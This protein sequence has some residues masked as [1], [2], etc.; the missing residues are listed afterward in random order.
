MGGQCER[1]S[2]EDVAAGAMEHAHFD[3]VIAAFAL[4]LIPSSYLKVVMTALARSCDY[5]V[6][7]S[8]HK[9]PKIDH[10]FAW[11]LVGPE[12]LHHR[13]HVRC[14]TSLG[15][16]E[17]PLETPDVATVAAAR[18][19]AAAA[20]AWAAAAAELEAVN[21]AKAVEAEEAEEAA[22]GA[23]REAAVREAELAEASIAEIT[24]EVEVMNLASLRAA[25]EGLGLDA[26][27]KKQIL[28]ERLTAARIKSEV[29][30][31][32]EDGSE[33]ASE[34]QP[35]EPLNVA[36]LLKRKQKKGKKSAGGGMPQ[37]QHPEDGDVEA[38]MVADAYVPPLSR[39]E[40]E[41][42]RKE[43][44]KRLGKEAR[45]TQAHN[46]GVGD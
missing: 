40:K 41:K 8:P 45:Q 38:D 1:W 2:F 14:F 42:R 25:L 9:R 44:K 3:I 10:N 28:A 15:G 32:I 12:V 18:A 13:I 36:P 34:E 39:K 46:D 6:L 35:P 16:L 21:T 5:L 43:E 27:G 37:E 31:E 19:R 17:R 23:M 22:M 11:E 30:G 33:D 29:E 26:H 20:K 24:A 7:A 4:H